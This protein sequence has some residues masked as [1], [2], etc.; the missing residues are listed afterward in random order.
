[1]DGVTDRDN[2]RLSCQELHF[3]IILGPLQNAHKLYQYGF[4]NDTTVKPQISIGVHPSRPRSVPVNQSRNLAMGIHDRIHRCAALASCLTRVDSQRHAAPHP[5]DEGRHI[6]LP[7]H[8][9]FQS[10]DGLN[11]AAGNRSAGESIAVILF[12]RTHYRLFD[13]WF[14][15]ARRF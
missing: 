3:R 10:I 6:A 13:F 4:T 1:M 9:I 5:L 2:N 8:R 11:V 14:S 15:N 12:R 7:R